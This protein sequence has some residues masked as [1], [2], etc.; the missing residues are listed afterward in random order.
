LNDALVAL[1]ED[2]AKPLQGVPGGL[3]FFAER[4]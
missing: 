3:N 1:G 4:R 2:P